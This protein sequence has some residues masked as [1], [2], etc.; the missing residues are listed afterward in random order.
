M[1]NKQKSTRQI[2]LIN[3]K[4]RD[5][6]RAKDPDYDEKSAQRPSPAYDASIELYNDGSVTNWMINNFGYR[7]E[8]DMRPRQEHKQFTS[9]KT[10]KTYVWQWD[11]VDD[12]SPALPGRSPDGGRWL[13][14]MKKN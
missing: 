9:Q 10:G 12:I 1:K 2:A 5:A 4:L 11:T 7:P 3:A 14:V 6:D 8:P 13:E